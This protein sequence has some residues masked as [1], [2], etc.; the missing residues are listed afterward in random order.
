MIDD[1]KQNSAKRDAD[2]FE[3]D[4][5]VTQGIARFARYTSPLMLAM[6]VSAGKSPALAATAE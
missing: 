3:P 5:G 1:S 2:V 4:A 6:L